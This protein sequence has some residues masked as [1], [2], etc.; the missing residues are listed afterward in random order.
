MNKLEQTSSIDAATLQK[1]LEEKREVLVVDV[2]PLEQ[3]QE[4]AIPGSIH[5]DVYT[6]LKSGD[7][8]AFADMTI[9]KNKPIVTVCA[10]GNMSQVAARQLAQAGHQVYSLEGGMKAWSSAWNVATLT[11]NDQGTVLQIRRTGKGCLSYIVGSADQALV[12][13]PSVDA[14][15][16]VQLARQHGWHIRYVLETHLHADHLS[17]ARGLANQTGAVL[18]LPSGD[19]RQYSYQPIGSGDLLS[20]GSLSLQAL[21]TPGHTHH[22]FSYWLKEGVLFTGDTLFTEGVGRP[23]LHSDWQESSGRAA[24]LHQSLQTLLAFPDETLVLPGH[25]SQPVEF[26]GQLISSRI[27]KLKVSLPLLKLPVGEFVRQ[28]LSR[29]PATPAN[30]TVITGRNAAGYFSESDS[31]EL[32]SGANRC[33]VS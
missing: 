12:I 14:E 24:L 7:G 23:D 4:W 17:R 11:L 2:R 30:Y 16:Y 10:A 6:N 15:V 25:T 21:A 3:R 5:A 29:I 22:S 26:D 32:E 18:V 8:D 13:D 20:V 33:A 19:D 28:I 27:G 1:W 9:P 31:L